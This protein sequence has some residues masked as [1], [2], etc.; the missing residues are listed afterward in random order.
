[1]PVERIVERVV[2]VEVEKV[3]VQEVVKYVEQYIDREVIKYVDRYVDREVI[4]EVP[5]DKIVVQV[6]RG[7]VPMPC[8]CCP[9]L[10]PGA[11]SATR[12]PDVC[13]R[14]GAG[15]A[16]VRRPG[17]RKGGRGARGSHRGEA[18]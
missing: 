5:V 7:S 2:E 15:G 16:G 11:V 9:P 12:A 6:I 8:V 14:P 10:L 13:A 4:K 1:M 18:C 17:G 3:V